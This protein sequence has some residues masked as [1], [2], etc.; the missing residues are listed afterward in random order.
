MAYKL[1]NP[2]AQSFYIDEP[3]VVTKVDLFFSDKDDSL[4]VRLSLRQNVNGIPGAYIIPFSETIIPSAS[5]NTSANANVATT[6]SFT[7]PIYLEAGEYSITLGSDSKNYKIY[8][9]ELDGVDIN[10]S[11]RITE[12]PYLGSLFKSQNASTWSPVQTEDLKFNLYRAVFD[13]SVKGSINFTPIQ[14]SYGFKQLENN[15]LEVFPSSTTMRVYHFNHGLQNGGSVMLSG[16][17]NARI[18]GNVVNAFYG[19]D[20]N[21]I[22]NTKLTV[23]NVT[24]QSY[25]VNLSTAASGISKATRFGGSGVLATQDIQYE[26][27]YPVIAAVNQGRGSIIP[28][29]KGTSTDYTLDTEFTNLAINDNILDAPKILASNTTTTYNLSNNKSLI[30]NIDITSENPYISPL[31]D[32]KQLGLVLVKNLIDSPTYDNKTLV[33][34]TQT[35]SNTST[36][37]NVTLESGNIGLISFK[38]TTDVA[39]VLTLVKGTYINITGT[40]PNNGQ[41][42]IIDV[43]DSGANVRVAHLSANVISDNNTSNLYVITN[44]SKYV[45]EEAVSGGS[46]Y[47]KYITR[48]FD[49]VNASSSINLRLDICKPADANIKLY[50]RIKKAGETEFSSQEFVEITDVTIPTSLSGE[51]YEVSSQVDNLSPFTSIVFKA[52]FLSTNSAKVPKIKNLRLIALA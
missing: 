33:Y 19:I 35:I 26:T 4:P 15:P 24:L 11:K 18:F 27:V 36:K 16:I 3:C 38:D 17:A 49:L 5:I 48:Q 31:I 30:Y 47:S 29:F 41:Y 43:I 2:L 34:D 50:Y 8:V 9:S 21:V 12:Q 52:V 13:T 44:S 1:I 25:T 7:S 45:A 20:S 10:T 42:R 39:N 6:I 37:A 32:S 46:A 40:N 14:G 28:K 23:S 22:E 51:F